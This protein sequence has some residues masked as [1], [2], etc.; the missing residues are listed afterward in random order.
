MVVFDKAKWHYDGEFRQELDI[1]Q[2]YVPIGM[3]VA[4]VIKNELCSKRTRKSDAS[5]IELV[6]QDKMTG[7]QFYRDNWDGVL[8]SNDLSDEADAF[9][10]EYLNIH[11]DI[12]TAVDFTEIVATGLPTIYHVED[13][14]ENYRMIE[15][16]ISERYRD[17]KQS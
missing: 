6:R 16:V 17:W 11:N 7:A 15:P 9:A 3:F 2:A 14:I 10:R 12:Y 4:W 1:F 5:D 13:T 8:S